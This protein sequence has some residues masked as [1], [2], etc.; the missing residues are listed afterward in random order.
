MPRFLWAV[1]A[2]LLA[3]P[4]LAGEAPG[5]PDARFKSAIQ[6]VVADNLPGATDTLLALEADPLPPDLQRQAD[7]LLGILLVHQSRWEQAV[8]WLSRAADTY[9]LLSDYARMHLAEAERRLGHPELAAAAFRAIADQQRDSLFFERASREL[10]RAYLDAGAL[11]EAE[12][13]ATKYLAGFP[14]G[15]GRGEVRLALGETL[16]RSGRTPEAEPLFRR[17]WVELPG[18]AEAQRA[19]E[20]LT[21]MAVRPFTP[22]EQFERA[23][24]LHATGRLSQAL[25][26]LAPFA[27]AGSPHERQARLL[28]GQS[29][30]Q[31]RLYAQAIQWLEPLQAT[32]GPE[33]FE[34]LFW[35]GRS[36]G[37]SGDAVRATDYLTHVVDARTQSP[38]AEEALYLL[39]QAAADDNDAGR[40]RTYLARL[41]QEYPKGSYTDVALWL[42]GWLAYKHQDY[43]VAVSSWERLAKEELG[44]RWRIASIYWRGRALEAQGR[45]ADAAKAYQLLLETPTDHFYYLLR[46][47]NRLAALKASA[48][49][50]PKEG[51]V[52]KVKSAA[53]GLHAKKGRALAGLGLSDESAEEWSEQVRQ[54]PEDRGGLAEAC[55]S[56]LDVGRYDRAVWLGNRILR[57]L[58][59]QDDGQLPIPGFW[60]CAFPLGHLDLVRQFAATR[61]L[62][63]YLV[64]ALIREESAFAPRATSSAGARGLMQLMPAVAEKVVRD[65]RL[66]ALGPGALEVPAVNIQL[67]VLYLADALRDQ[68]GNL[69]LALAEYNAGSAAVQRWVQRY[70]FSDEE[71]FIED[72]PYT[73]TR[74]YVKRV[75]ANYE[76]YRTVYG[77]ANVAQV[78][79]VGKTTAAAH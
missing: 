28:L 42:Q 22:D 21:G 75:L 41:L 39:G 24:T 52:A 15:H 59:V 38:R 40:S 13:A 20:L 1:L 68:N 72:I 71:Q 27:V 37:R 65:N 19:K 67:G 16:L 18:S 58:Y 61:N 73:E 63:P 35:L 33:R 10:P 7:L 44:S 46:G 57:P 74:N 55:R 5:P 70:G 11:A 64:L 56:F 32:T 78:L 79:R 47:R 4:A 69:A 12:T 54:H 49:R 60:E 2:L 8:P 77:T 48:P 43:G 51:T 6:Q 36:A 34:A 66:P 3:M 26:E 53:L 23:V 17:L 30:F 45:R 14:A 9:P 29:A 50:R 76:R 31:A 25:Q 62:D